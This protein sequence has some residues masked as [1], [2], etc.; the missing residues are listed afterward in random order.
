MAT[1]YRVDLTSLSLTDRQVAFQN[2]K[3][4]AWGVYQVLGPS[5]LEGVDVIW[6]LPDDFQTSPVF[7]KGCRCIKLTG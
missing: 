2:M 6:D 7:P 5:G 1:R 3:T 4:V